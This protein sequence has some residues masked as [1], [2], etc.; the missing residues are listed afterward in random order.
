[1]GIGGKKVPRK[2]PG[3]FAIGWYVPRDTVEFSVP[4]TQGDSWKTCKIE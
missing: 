2:L 3:L 1:M 4:E